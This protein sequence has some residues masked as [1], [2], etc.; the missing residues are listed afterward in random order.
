M[1]FSRAR[2]LALTWLAL[3]PLFALAPSPAQA[4]A[5]PVPAVHAAPPAPP[6]PATPPVVQPPPAVVAAP[7]APPPAAPLDVAADLQTLAQLS[8]QAAATSSDDRLQAMASQAAGIEA[9]AQAV[10]A[11]RS[12]DLAAVGKAIA[13][14]TPRERRTL[15]AAERAKAAPLLAQQAALRPQLSQAQAV[16]TAARNAY[17]LIAERRRQGFSARL[18]A[19]SASPVSPEF[20][21]Q[22]STAVGPDNDRL[23]AMSQEAVDAALA[24]PEPRALAG[25]AAG[26]LFALALA[27][28]VR[29]RLERLGRRKTGEAA[30]SG[31]ARTGAALWLAAVGAG[32]PTLAAASLHLAAQWGGLLS[33]EADALAD[34]AV[35]ATAWA[36]AIG[37]LARVLVTDK[38]RSHRLLRLSNAD[39]ARMRLPL[40]AVAL[41]TAGGFMLTR[42]N[43][44]VGASVAATIAANC[45]LSIAYAAVAAWILISFAHRRE[46]GGAP[47]VAAE[48][49][50]APAWTLI[51]LLLTLAIAVTVGAVF[52]GY[53]TLAALTSG[54][55]FWLSIIA[56]SAYLMMRFVDDLCAAAFQDHGRANQALAQLFRLRGATIRQAGV[57]VSAALQILVLIGALSLALTPFG[58]S[59]DL[60]F[61]NLRELGEPIRFGSATISLS[62]I[63]AGVATFIVGLAAAHLVQR[64]VVRRYLPATDWDAGLR[65]SVTTGVGYLGV[66]VAFTCALAATGLGLSQIAL[67]AS[68]LSVGIGFGLQQVVQNFVS[69]VILLVERP[70]KVGDW[71]NIGGI[72][73]DIRRIR[74]RA[75]EIQTFDRSTVIVPNS[76]LITK[77][78][79]NKTL[80]EP[81]GRVVLQLSITRPKD[82]LQARQIILEVAARK[83]A[84]VRDPA[85]SVFIESLAPSG[86]VNLACFLYVASPRA[87]YGVRSECYFDILYALQANDIPFAGLNPLT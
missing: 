76:D 81:L 79:Q 54:Q 18:L 15:T 23:A 35:V 47:E 8:N 59:G 21:T 78:V 27:F 14:I 69:G 71:V 67:I 2:R 73:G 44:V 51:S 37:A 63:A 38:D 74:V 33:P 17:S 11:A 68:A 7:I 9:Q 22:L 60:L 41:V 61:A 75:T 66:I 29:W 52:A 32:A 70:V 28:P 4:A 10:A 58:H 53:T 83:P 46:E 26:L 55:I 16:V 39:A 5:A 31:F 85:P 6:P 12:G 1:T 20:W 56:A 87:T 19:K 62:A 36:A 86:A 80:G 49:A 50:R 24:A 82:V 40:M 84:I 34:A 72:E 3:W 48:P 30:R 64:W 57:L 77:S 65:N 13:R 25:M 42:L 43:Y 45:V